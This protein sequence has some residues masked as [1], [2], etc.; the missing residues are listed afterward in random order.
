MR[1]AVCI[2]GQP[3]TWRVSHKNIQNYF[4]IDGV[5]VDYFIHTWDTN[6]YRGKDET[7]DKKMIFKTIESEEHDINECFNPKGFIF[8]KF[9]SDDFGYYFPLFYSFMKSVWLKRKY[10]LENDFVY[11]IV[12]KTRFDINFWQ[13]GINKVGEPLNKF[14]IHKIMPL[15]AYN[16]NEL[17]EKFALEFN[18]INFDD[19]FFYSDSHT[20]DLI[21][22]IYWWYRKIV[23]RSE[24]SINN[25]SW[26]KD[27][28]YYYG[29][30][31][32]L[33]RYL[34]NHNIHMRCDIVI[35]Y[36]VVR[37]ECEFLNL[38][39]VKDWVE[40]KDISHDFYWDIR[41]KGIIE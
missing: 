27:N 18:A 30:G 10:E 35:P 14:Y 41:K 34:T 21:T 15:V 24:E 22:N 20:M 37:K 33:Y 28:E 19:V 38:D 31:T 2:S 32:L 39:S 16:A 25:G 6:T 26:V 4:D 11:D 3:R 40:I 12:I 29:P 36:Y 17:F 5:D 13:E 23:K 1:I 8:E 9:K 7:A